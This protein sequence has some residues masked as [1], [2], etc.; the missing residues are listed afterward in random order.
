MDDFDVPSTVRTFDKR[1]MN[2]MDPETRTIHKRLA[3]W[4]IWAFEHRRA[5]PA[6]TLLG[7]LIEQGPHGAGQSGALPLERSPANERLDSVVAKLCEIDKWALDEYYR[8]AV[9]LEGIARQKRKTVRQV[10][11]I[12]NRARWRAKIRLEVLEDQ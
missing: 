8:K 2:N 7:R 5:W 4:G 10:Q 1:S 6:I 3:A 12:L 11:N 9:P